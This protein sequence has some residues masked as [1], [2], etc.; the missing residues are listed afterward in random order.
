MTFGREDMEALVKGEN[1]DKSSLVVLYAP[2]CSFSQAMDESYNDVAEKLAGSNVVVGKFNADGA[3]KAYA[4]E[5]LQLQSYPTVL[6][7]PKNSSQI[8]KY[9]SENREVDA[10]L[11]FVQALQ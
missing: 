2:W 7:L 3:Q 8:I 9:P 6:F 1:R 10:L 11:G 5:N 4:K